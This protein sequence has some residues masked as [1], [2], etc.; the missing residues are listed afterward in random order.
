LLT[1]VTPYG[2]SGASSRVR[3][4]EWLDHL[5]VEASSETY[6]DTASAGLGVLARHPI[7]A[8]RAELRLR[9]LARSGS[10]PLLLSRNASPLS[11]GRVESALL[12]R[13]SHGVY[14][15]DDALMHDTASGLRG[16]F[17]KERIWRNAVAAAD[18]VIAGNSYLADAASTINPHVEIIPSCVEPSA[19]PQKDDFEV[20]RVPTAVWLGSP[21]TEQYLQLIS[22]ALLAEHA[23]SGLRL[24][25]ISRGDAP[26]GEL[27]R[28]VDR[29][30]WSI[31]TFAGDLIAA[32]FGIMPLPDTPW[33]RGK[34]AYKL[35]QYA[36]A[37][38]PAIGSPVGMN[39]NVLHQLGFAAAQDEHDWT[40][41]LR[42]SVDASA[43]TR[44]AQ[45]RAA[46]TGVEEHF[47][48][49]TWA[50]AWSRSVLHT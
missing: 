47:S 9:R 16:H 46:R 31:D 25:L 15:F 35:L 33:T 1:T 40:D 45:G 29:I 8:G 43:A 34:C 10:G 11:T 42:C 30:S 17:A 36:A 39:L 28:M 4:F 20:R 5:S 24:T 44:T 21:S 27:G 23:R 37:G 26:L 12:R 38:L 6:L 19:Y 13:S 14:D 3:V 2:R 22:R 7:Q 18:V 48:F 49:R 50:P 41:T 32:D